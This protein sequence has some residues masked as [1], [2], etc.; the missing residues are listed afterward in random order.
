MRE[1]GR[2]YRRMEDGGK[3]EGV[4]RENKR[5]REEACLESSSVFCPE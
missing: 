2:E 4:K 3:M 1:G 5:E